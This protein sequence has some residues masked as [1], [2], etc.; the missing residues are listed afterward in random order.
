MPNTLYCTKAKA[1][2]KELNIPS[3]QSIKLST[4][5]S[6]ALVQEMFLNR[7]QKQHHPLPPRSVLLTL[8][9]Q[10]SNQVVALGLEHLGLGNSQV[11]SVQQLLELCHQDHQRLLRYYI[12]A[13]HELWNTDVQRSIWTQSGVFFLSIHTAV[14]A[15]KTMGNQ[16]STIYLTIEPLIEQYPEARNLVFLW[17]HLLGDHQGEPLE[18]KLVW[19]K[20][21]GTAA[22]YD[23]VEHWLKM[24][25]REVYL[26][27]RF[28]RV[29]KIVIKS[30]SQ[31][32]KN[33][34]EIACELQV[35]IRTVEGHCRNIL[36]RARK[37]FQ[38]PQFRTAQEVAAY[39]KRQHFLD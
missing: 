6:L 10:E 39:L 35:S 23:L 15:T 38:Q 11:Y 19:Q 2:S 32:Q 31:Q 1:M 27:L 34:P 16:Y 33:V 7:W 22:V 8:N 20:S 17:G 3:D 25:R 29:Q 13:M 21:Q 24:V 9:L 28:T 4:D 18:V 12:K 26:R 37:V 14:Q 36:S 5:F 30:L